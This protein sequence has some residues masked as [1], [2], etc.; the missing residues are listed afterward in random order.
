[1]RIHRYL[2]LAATALTLAA[3]DELHAQQDGLIAHPNVYRVQFENDWVR[4]IRVNVPAGADLAE[5]THPPGLMLHVYFNDADPILFEHDGPPGSVTR[6]YVKARSYRV[7]R[8][9][10]EAHAVINRGRTSSD[11][12][13]IELKTIGTESRGRRVEAPPLS[14]TTASVVE[15]TNAQYR[16]T[17]ITV[18]AGKTFEV[19]TAAGEPA[20]IVA[21]TEGIAVDGTGALKLGGE[22]F[23]DAGGSAL[24]R[25]AGTASVELLRV[26]FLTA[27]EKRSP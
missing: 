27:P 16:A 21:L 3:A 19:K 6:P 13:R 1:M 7:G 14:D 23:A 20:L 4:L 11:Y 10:P 25:N 15:V 9:R 5:H 26:D 8:A 12:M 22:R 2:T 18:G 24:V 17:R